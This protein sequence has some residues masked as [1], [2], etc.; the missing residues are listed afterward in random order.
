MWGDFPWKQY[1]E[2]YHVKPT[3]VHP[4]YIQQLFE[5]NTQPWAQPL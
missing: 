5:N 2:V 4:T 3:H 1:T